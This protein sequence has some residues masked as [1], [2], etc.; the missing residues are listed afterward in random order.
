M[1]KVYLS[2]PITGLTYNDA[3]YSWRSDVM[4]ALEDHAQV[5]SPMRHEG[6]LAEMKTA[7]SEAALKKFQQTNNHFF[8]QNKM[9]VAKD[10]LDIDES[11]I[12]LTNFL[13]AKVISKGTIA[14]LG[15]AYAKGKTIITVME[16][17]N[18]NDGP[19]TREMSDTVL[20]NLED[21]IIVIKSLLS[22]G[23]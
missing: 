19:F 17:G 9:I 21:A 2:G 5:L 13:G 16:E 7:M 1:S 11:T 12:V 4:D 10:L 8:S 6:H 15:Y 22:T 23:I 3:R 14:E 20:D 18:P